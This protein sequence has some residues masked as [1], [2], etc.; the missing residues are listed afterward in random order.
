LVAISVASSLRTAEAQ[1][2]SAEL[3]VYARVSYPISLPPIRAVEFGTLTFTGT[4]GT[5]T[6]DELTGAVTHAGGVIGSDGVAQRGEIR[7]TAPAAGLV[8]IY[9]ASP[10][11]PLDGTIAGPTSVYFSPVPSVN[12]VE[13]TAGEEIVVFVGGILTLAANTPDD[14]YAGVITIIVS[15]T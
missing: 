12:A 10:Q 11:V 15:Y 8:A 13:V 6:I 14:S 7:F 2:G 4:P 5:M 1:G 3:G 9:S